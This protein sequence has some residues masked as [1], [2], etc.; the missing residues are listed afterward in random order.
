MKLRKINWKGAAL[1]A[2][3]GFLLAS[4]SND[5]NEPS[6][7]GQLNGTQLLK[8]P[9][10][11]AWS[12]SE[13]LI[14]NNG[15]PGTRG[16]SNNNANMWNQ[17]WDCPE[18]VNLSEDDIAEI[19]RRLSPGIETY[20][21]IILPWEN[22]W[23]QQVY[24]GQAPDEEYIM[25][26]RVG[27]E[28]GTVVG[29]S[30]MDKLMAY[31]ETGYE[32]Y[33]DDQLQQYVTVP[34]I[35]INN[36]NSGSN[37]NNPGPC[38]CGVVHT[39]TTLMEQM[40]TSGIDANSQFAFHET[41]STNPQYY[42]NYLIIEYKGYYY[43]G[44]D[45][46]MHKP[47]VANDNEEYVVERDWKFT[48]WIVRISPAY[49][50]HTNSDNPGGILDPEVE[51]CPC[52]NCE[53]PES[54]C[55]EDG[56]CGHEDCTCE[57]CQKDDD[58]EV[59]PPIDQPDV[60]TPAELQDEVEI[61]LS[62]DP[63]RNV[64]DL[65]TKLSIHV[66]SATDV[67]VVIPMPYKYLCDADDLVLF[68]K[69]E[70]SE[71]MEHGGTSSGNVVEYNL[72]GNKVTLTYE[73]DMVNQQII[74]TTDGINE[75]VI[76]YLKEKNNDGINFEIYNYYGKDIDGEIY[77][78]RTLQE[79]LNQATV[80]FLDKEPDYYINA[81]HKDENGDIFEG[82]CDVKIIDRQF[83]NYN[84]NGPG[85]HYNGSPYNEFYENKNHVNSGD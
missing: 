75:E 63:D 82:D 78:W 47:N 57:N 39:G 15:T 16:W 80:E 56:G 25:Y 43:V 42:N 17:N 61:N 4:C 58:P 45:Y 8:A 79:Y 44:F 74:V 29:S 2:S 14:P 64:T 73:Y 34:Y 36:F 46:E 62:I 65:I 24:T 37:N 84:Y 5:L 19:K 30:K 13:T 77:D 38:G 18:E 83:G 32:G 54:D 66:R 51:N 20:N 81:F 69:H 72:N 68:D 7:N 11:K 23:V 9:K 40:P 10:F 31:N 41:I 85:K 35:H 27:G 26:N 52:G 53:H 67:R 48:D 28:A 60:D 50:A 59:T 71:F 55:D 76:N 6:L 1:M 22:Y 21:N 12:G 3:A 33:W 70:G 49:P